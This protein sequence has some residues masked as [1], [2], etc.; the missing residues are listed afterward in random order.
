MKKKKGAKTKEPN[1]LS[2]K[3]KKKVTLKTAKD[4]QVKEKKPMKEQEGKVEL[5]R[6]ARDTRKRQRKR[7]KKSGSGAANATEQGKAVEA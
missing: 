6:A 7:A 2:V 1:P 4:G 3:K 5:M